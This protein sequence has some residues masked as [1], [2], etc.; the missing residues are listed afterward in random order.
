MMGCVP[1]YITIMHWNHS[2]CYL[3]NKAIIWEILF[4][5][6]REEILFMKRMLQTLGYFWVG[7]TGVKMPETLEFSQEI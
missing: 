4:W 6:K 5:A 3:E 1:D 2:A 7:F